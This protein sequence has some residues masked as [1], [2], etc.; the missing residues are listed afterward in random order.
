MSEDTEQKTSSF[1][2]VLTP[3]FSNGSWNGSVT[4]HIEEE[5]LDDLGEIEIS[6]IRNACGM[7]ASSIMLME[8]DEEFR[9]YVRNFFVDNFES[10]IEDIQNDMPSFTRSEDGKVITLHMNTKTH[11][12]A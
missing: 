3:E 5:I 9:D 8:L 6:Q 4:A 12:S 7:M 1:A 2:V 10:F 11:G